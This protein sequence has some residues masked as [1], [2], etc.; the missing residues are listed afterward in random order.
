MSDNQP[1]TSPSKITLQELLDASEGLSASLTDKEGSTGSRP[2]LSPEA[3]DQL[4]RSVD[5]KIDAK[6][7][8][9]HEG[10]RFTHPRLISYFN[11]QLGWRAGEATLSIGERWCYIRCEVT[12]FLILKIERGER[13]AL[14]AQLNNEERLALHHL[15][16]RG[17][18]LFAQL[19][20]ERLA[21]L[22]R[23]AQAQCEAWLRSASPSEPEASSGFCLEH[24]GVVWP[25]REMTEPDGG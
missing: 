14:W 13:G 12:P 18:V 9:W 11:R 24:E 1:L 2:Q 15:E 17:E 20:P 16:L 10:E 21:R 4:R 8:W 6:G 5:L 7:R 23:H 22:S 19:T 25:I 3:L